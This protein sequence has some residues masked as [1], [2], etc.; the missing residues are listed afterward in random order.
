MLEKLKRSWHGFKAGIPG[1]RFHQQ[2][3]R[4]QQSG[5]SAIQKTLFIGGGLLVMAAGLFFLF[6][7][8]PGLIIFL[9]GACLI[10]QQSLLAARALDSSEM[11]MRRLLVGS[12]R[13]WRA[14]SPAL[15]ILLF[16]FAV[17]AV[18]VVGFSAFRFLL[19]Y[20]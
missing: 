9:L 16:V 11:R 8:G 1:H 19:A 12:S 7:P 20:A 6:V 14:S 17:V 10:A 13:A 3:L 15:K 4:H 2:F 5:P 18:G